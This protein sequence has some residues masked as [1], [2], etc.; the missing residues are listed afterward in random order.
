MLEPKKFHSAGRATGFTHT[1]LFNGRV[2]MLG[3]IALLVEIKRTWPADLV[4]RALL[5]RSAAEL[6]MG[7][8]PRA[9]LS[10]TTT[11]R[12]ALHQGRSLSFRDQ[13]AAQAWRTSLTEQGMG[14]GRLKRLIGGVSAYD[15][16]G[17]CDDETIATVGIPTD[18]RLTV[19]VSSQVGCPMACRFCV[20]GKGGL[21]RSLHLHEIVDQVLS[22]R[23]AMDRRPSH[24]VH[25]NG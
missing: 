7:C 10:W 17:R 20:T 9:S 14:V 1:E 13:C 21:R 18:Q 19:C 15:R 5:G 3:F 24:C 6:E 25:G 16:C 8:F 22:V 12:L 23:E 4:S 2:A 11:S